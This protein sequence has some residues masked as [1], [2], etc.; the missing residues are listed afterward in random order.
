[1]NWT[2]IGQRMRARR[3]QCNL[4][5]EEL[6]SYANTSNI[7]ICRIENGDARPTLVKLR[8]LCEALDCPLSYMIDGKDIPAYDKNAEQISKLMDGCSPYLIKL[9]KRI[10]ETIVNDEEIHFV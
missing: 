6:A 10:V 1:M 2:L 9:I 5:Q 3:L 4:T 7:Y 8:R